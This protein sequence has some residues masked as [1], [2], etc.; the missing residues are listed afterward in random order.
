MLVDV[1][2]DLERGEVCC[3]LGPSGSGKST[4]LNLVGG[5]EHADGGTIQVGGT[6]VT[7]LKP[8]ALGEYRRSQLG[9]IFQFYNLVPDLT[10]LE[11]PFVGDG[12]FDGCRVSNEI[13]EKLPVYLS[14]DGTA[15][16]VGMM[17]CADG[18]SLDAVSLVRVIMNSELSGHSAKRAESHQ[19]GTAESSNVGMS[20][21]PVPST[22]PSAVRASEG[23]K[24]TPRVSEL[25]REGVRM[26]M[27]SHLVPC[28]R[29]GGTD[30]VGG[31]RDSSDRA[32]GALNRALVS[33]V[34]V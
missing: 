14:D 16:M 33:A 22:S 30:L 17:A 11:Y 28:H 4:F 34:C 12:G 5:L 6:E 9:F 15:L 25:R 2:V 13:V 31:L 19:P 23:Q 3:L 1:S 29:E 21:S 26:F 18:D 7:A 32:Q 10:V 27:G 20:V 24:R 8:R